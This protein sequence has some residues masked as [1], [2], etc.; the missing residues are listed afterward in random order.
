MAGTGL[1]AVAFG[2]SSNIKAKLSVLFSVKVILMP[3][4]VTALFALILSASPLR[5]PLYIVIFVL[6]PSDC[7]R[8]VPIMLISISAT[9]M[10]NSIFVVFLNFIYDH[11][12][13]QQI[14]APAR[15][16]IPFQFLG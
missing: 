10:S 6:P 15:F 2:G 1:L 7:A 4:W 16:C 12:L 3:L 9:D 5:V 13:L 11:L 14:K 8:E